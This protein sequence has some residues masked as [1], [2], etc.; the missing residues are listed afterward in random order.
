MFPNIGPTGQFPRGKLHEDDQGSLRASVGV[1]DGFIVINFG[2]TLNWLALTPEGALQQ[3][4]AL[5]RLAVTHGDVD[6]DK[7]DLVLFADTETDQ[8]MTGGIDIQIKN[9]M[10]EITFPLN[11]EQV[12]FDPQGAFAFAMRLMICVQK[13]RPDLATFLPPLPEDW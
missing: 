9:G 4:M 7:L 3:C 11:V 10:I 13:L 2:T 12:A 8:R 5:G 1:V 6:L